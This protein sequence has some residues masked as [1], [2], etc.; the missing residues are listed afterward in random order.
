MAQSSKSATEELADAVD[1][2]RIPNTERIS[3]LQ[4]IRVAKAV[5][6]VEKRRQM[7]RVR[8]L[9]VSLLGEYNQQILDVLRMI[10][11]QSSDPVLPSLCASSVHTSSDSYA[12]STIFLYEP[13]FIAQVAD[14]VHP[15][16]PAPL[17]IRTV[18]LLTLDT[19][20]RVRNKV[21]EVT[22]ALS[23]SVNHGTL[24]SILRRLHSDL[25]SGSCTLQMPSA[26]YCAKANNPTE[27]CFDFLSAM[28]DEANSEYI[29]ALFNFLMHLQTTGFAGNMLLGAGIIPLLIDLV[30]E[31]SGTPETL[32][33]ANRAV[34]FLDNFTYSFTVAAGPFATAGGLTVFVERVK[35]LVDSGVRLDEGR[36]GMQ[37]EGND[38]GGEPRNLSLRKNRPAE[39]LKRDKRF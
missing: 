30:K 12:E 14:L 21:G 1:A 20:S 24:M 35:E 33:A 19:V 5:S 23:V 4:R 34:T 3:L 25:Q 28:P 39:M 2:H 7:L 16:H 13:D 32:L 10:T 29:D 38:A 37:I 26:C 18:A 9:A 22:S 15:E 36:S 11:C 17:T 31:N 8:L 27:R 6:D